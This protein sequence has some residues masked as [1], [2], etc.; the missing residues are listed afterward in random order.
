MP[1]LIDGH[2]L[3]GQLPDIS[4]DDPHDEAK[5][6]QKLAGFA[7]RTGKR[8]TVIFDSG[9]PGGKSRMSNR[10]VEVVFASRPSDADRLLL[11]RIN[12]TR[13]PKNWTVVSSDN[14][15]L[16][17]ARAR[18]MQGMKSTD[19]AKLLLNPPREKKKKQYGGKAEMDV[20]VSPQE[21]DEWLQVFGD[22][23]E[24]SPPPPP[25][26]GKRKRRGR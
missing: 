10:A 1:Y 16:G 23:S 8:C 3:I 22:D 15:V 11:R 21:V 12:R 26:E 13:D 17:A 2:N 20:Y 7:A 14:A 9:L 25:T 6:V 24:A 18:G 19:F 4:L 5:L